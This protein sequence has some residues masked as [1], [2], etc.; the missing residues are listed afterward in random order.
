MTGVHD[1]EAAVGQDD[2]LSGL[3]V[4]GQFGGEFLR[5]PDAPVHRRL[6]EHDLAADAGQ[7]NRLGP[8]HL[9]LQ[10]GGRIGELDRLGPRKAVGPSGGQGR[11]HHVARTGHVVH[12]AGR[13]RHVQRL[14]VPLQQH[15][16][17]PV[18]RQH[19]RVELQPLHHGRRRLG[20]GHRIGESVV[21]RLFEFGAVGRHRGGSGVAGPVD[22]V[23][24]IHEDGH[25]RGPRQLDDGLAQGLAADTLAV[26]L[27]ADDVDGVD[28][29]P[30]HGEQLTFD[31]VGYGIR[32]LN[33]DPEHLLG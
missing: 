22:T 20:I 9:D 27:E 24:R 12:A 26:V 19:H 6:P 7:R 29:R 31:G 32:R 8:E 15:R 2:A 18:E 5:S 21:D 23:G 17:V 28:G 13:G 1:V 16:S 10:S 4:H 25:P 14:G 33:I 11:Q 3:A 30:D